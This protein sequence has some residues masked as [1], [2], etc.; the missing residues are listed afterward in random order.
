VPQSLPQLR[1]QATFEMAN[2]AEFELMDALRKNADIKDNRY[3]FF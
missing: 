3:T 2:S 1:R